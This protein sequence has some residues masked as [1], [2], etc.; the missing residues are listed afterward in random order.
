MK[1]TH[2]LQHVLARKPFLIVERFHFLA[3]AFSSPSNSIN[4][5]E[6][7]KQLHFIKF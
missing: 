5:S 2:P 6:I 4:N 7:T 3:N 1:E